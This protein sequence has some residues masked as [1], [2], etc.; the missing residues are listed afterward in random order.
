MIEDTVIDVALFR[1]HH[2]RTEMTSS[3]LPHLR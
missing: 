1:H 3:L 2:Q